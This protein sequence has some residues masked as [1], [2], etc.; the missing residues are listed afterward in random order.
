MPHA[1]RR[2]FGMSRKLMSVLKSG[3]A[4]HK[5]PLTQLD[6]A[7]GRSASRCCQGNREPAE[8][9]PLPVPRDVTS[10]DSSCRWKRESEA[11]R[12]EEDVGSGGL[13]R[14]V[15]QRR[16][17]CSLLWTCALCRRWHICPPR[18]LGP[19]LP[20]LTGTVRG[21]GLRPD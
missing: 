5:L 13:R 16:S 3:T 2:C 4:P 20:V 11:E 18:R 10:G 9:Q 12:R 14:T 1:T 21:T 17:C 6:R 15:L 8:G 7:L 19:P